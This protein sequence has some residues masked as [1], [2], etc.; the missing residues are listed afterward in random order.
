MNKRQRII[1]SKRIHEK[2]MRESKI[3]SYAYYFAETMIKRA[4]KALEI[5]D[6]D[7]AYSFFVG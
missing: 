2:N 3:F 6:D 1:E 5:A 4:E 7:E